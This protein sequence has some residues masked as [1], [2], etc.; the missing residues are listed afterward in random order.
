MAGGWRGLLEEESE[1]QWLTLCLF[2]VFVVF[3]AFAT[4]ATEHFVGD[5]IVNVEAQHKG[6]LVTEIEYQEE[7]GAYSALVY[8]PNAGYHMFTEHTDGAISDIYNP[9]TNDLGGQVNF[10]KTM[11]GG[12]L[13][14]SVEAN[15]L[16]GLQGNLMI[17]YDY[18]SFNETFT[19]HDAA[20]R[21]GATQTDRLLLTMEGSSTS[22]RGVVAGVPTSAMSMSSGV[23][24]HHVESHSDGLWAAIGTH[25][26]TSGADGSSPAS[27]QAR[28]VLGW[29]TWAGDTSTPVLR[30][31]Q[32]FGSGIFHSF[33]QSGTDLIVGG[34][35]ESLVISADEEV[36]AISAPCAMAVSDTEG[37]VWFIAPLGSTSLATYEDGTLDIHQLSRHVPVDVTDAGA[38]GEQVHVH[39]TDGEGNPIQWSIDIT[40]DGSIESGRGFLNLLFLLSGG[41]LLAMMA[42]HAIE[43][44]RQKA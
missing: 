17:T 16:M 31:V 35:A 36:K 43:Q 6:G 33:A 7:R 25:S 9:E 26:S 1:H 4:D 13:V 5:Q 14:F 38:Q 27:P 24:W 29:I 10:I 19:I 11:P 23:H 44:L 28:P 32:M 41:I 40:A 15:Q 39:G 12:E 34:T 21:V 22:F 2:A 30:N 37:K 42:T 3:G 18:T 20:D 8:A